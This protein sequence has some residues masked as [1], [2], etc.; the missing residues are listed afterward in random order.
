MARSPGLDPGHLRGFESRSLDM[1]LL[2]EFDIQLAYPED[3]FVLLT[4]KQFWGFLWRASVVASREIVTLSSPKKILDFGCGLGL[5]SLVASK[6]GHLVWAYDT[7]KLCYGLIEKSSQ[8]NNIECPRFVDDISTLNETFDIVVLSDVLYW[9]DLVDEIIPFTLNLLNHTG[10]LLIT[11]PV[12]DNV[13]QYL[14]DALRD[15]SHTR[16]RFEGDLT[17]DIDASYYLDAGYE[18]K[19]IDIIK[20]NPRGLTE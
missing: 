12:R 14:L 19:A 16:E 1:I 9:L 20:T 11:Q 18:C 10:Y 3:R 4:K 8:A 5:T 6:H 13:H 7:E 2:N 15:V 17:A